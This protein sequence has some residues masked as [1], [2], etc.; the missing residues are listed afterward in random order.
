MKQCDV[1]EALVTPKTLGC[2]IHRSSSINQLSVWAHSDEGHLLYCSCWG[3]GFFPIV[4]DY[5][6][7]S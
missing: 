2:L 5:L 3:L 4:L 1:E 6:P 7:L